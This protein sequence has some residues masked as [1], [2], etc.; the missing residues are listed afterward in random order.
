M[1]ERKKTHIDR[2]DI[3]IMTMIMNGSPS[4]HD[5]RKAI[6]VSS[7]G[8]I[9]ERLKWLQA[10]GLIIQPAFR[11]ARSRKITAKGLTELYDVGLLS[12]EDLNA[13]LQILDR[14]TSAPQTV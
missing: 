5:M 3:L 13:R 11:Q 9:D 8:T 14:A 6:Q 12:K 4:V 10:Q 7:P 1:K 2:K